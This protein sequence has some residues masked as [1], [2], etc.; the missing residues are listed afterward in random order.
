MLSQSTQSCIDTARTFQKELLNLFSNRSYASLQLV[1][2]LA[3]ASKPTS[4]VELSEEAPFE[5]SYS[6]INK[7]L[8][9][10]GKESLVIKEINESGAIKM[11]ESI[12]SVI[13]SKITKPF[14]SLFVKML[15]EEINRKFRLFA[16]DATSIPRIH[17][18]CLD[19]RSYVH[20]ANQ[21]GVPVTIGIEASVVVYLPERTV[22]EANWQLPVSIERISTDTTACAVAKTQLQL[23]D[24]LTSSDSRLM[25]IVADTAY[26]SLQPH[27]EDQVVIARDRTDRQGRRP[28]KEQVEP[29]GKGRPRKYE[30]GIIRFIEDLPP[31]T[32]GG[33]DEE[34]EYEDTIKNLP[35]DVLI[36]RWND[37]HVEGHAE[38]VDI[39]KIEVLANPTF[40]E[41]LSY[42]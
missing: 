2:A 41:V 37:V 21:I 16:L 35:V 3:Y 34:F 27:S 28:A 25:V 5:R 8:D 4:V 14:S 6:T 33:S 12:D 26:G 9:S 11:V 19:D 24:E 1:E 7:I 38:L 13:F 29:A 10:F 17:A 23:L 39:V 18:H 15:S 32:E 20:Q 31:G 22:E 36:N 40:A 30:P 42:E